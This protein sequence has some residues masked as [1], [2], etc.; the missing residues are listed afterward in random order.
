METWN[1]I[2]E[3]IKSIS[4]IP[5]A[6]PIQELTALGVRVGGHTYNR[7]VLGREEPRPLLMAQ[8]VAAGNNIF[9]TIL[10]LLLESLP[11]RNNF[12]V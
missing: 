6:N 4:L 5:V 1:L 3:N 10:N 2:P 11:T 12:T 7:L 8:A 9:P